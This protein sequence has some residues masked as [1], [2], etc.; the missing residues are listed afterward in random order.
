R[1]TALKMVEK[2]A[3]KEFVEEVMKE[4]LERFGKRALRITTSEGSE[5]KIFVKGIEEELPQGA[6][7]VGGIAG[8]IE[9][10]KEKTVYYSLKLMEAAARNERFVTL[11]NHLSK[12]WLKK[13][14]E[15]GVITKEAAEYIA[16]E[17]E[18]G[19]T[20]GMFLSEAEKKALDDGLKNLPVDQMSVSEIEKV[21]GDMV[22][23]GK[24]VPLTKEEIDAMKQF[25]T[26]SKSERVIML[27]PKYYLIDQTVGETMQSI[28]ELAGQKYL[29]ENK[30]E[31]TLFFKLEGQK[32]ADGIKLTGLE[33]GHI[34]R[35][36][37]DRAGPNPTF[38]LA[39]PCAADLKVWRSKCNEKPWYK[40]PL[41][42]FKKEEGDVD[43]IKVD[44]DMSNYDDKEHA[45]FCYTMWLGK[46]FGVSPWPCHGVVWLQ[47][48][49][50]VNKFLNWIGLGGC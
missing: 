42:W 36:E 48:I 15:K 46:S 24:I 47:N 20:I 21:L 7:E 49:P 35:V 30:G 14:Y 6:K 31:Y 17:L 38:Y 27:T 3:A 33:K 18:K 16:R 10:G 13:A 41:S 5:I 39:S 12:I 37:L 22:E 45:N 4:G 23:K 25:I 2:E 32:D 28:D 26:P 19:K 11:S 1:A 50:Y 43:C 9:K 44:V 8:L 29:D 40:R 34:A